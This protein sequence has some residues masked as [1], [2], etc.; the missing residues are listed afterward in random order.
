MPK[1]LVT[2]DFFTGLPFWER[3]EKHEQQT[4]QHETKE[5]ARALANEGMSR[6]ETGKHLKALQEALKRTGDF[7]AFCNTLHFSYRTAYRRIERYEWAEENLSPRVLELAGARGMDIVGYQ[8]DRPYGAYTE[9]I[10]QLPPP[11]DPEKAPEWLDAIEAK[12]KELPR[13]RAYRS[14]SPD[15]SLR[16]AFAAC[17][18]RFKSVPAGK[19]RV[20]WSKRLIGLLMAEM[21]LPGQHFEP[22][23]VPEG[24]RP[25]VGRP[26]KRNVTK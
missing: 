19:G 17:Y 16:M 11:K 9:P 22:E 6:L 23:A 18:R 1:D 25:K 21:G 12:R 2:K 20:A 3:L 26:K 4:V 8:T 10:K 5:L 24:F 14:V 15:I 7:V 13:K